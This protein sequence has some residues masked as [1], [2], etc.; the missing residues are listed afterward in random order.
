MTHRQE[1][2]IMNCPMPSS[3]S[4]SRTVPQIA[5]ANL[6]EPRRISLMSEHTRD[7]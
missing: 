1:A 6:K 7:L 2:T 5:N 4:G 3:V